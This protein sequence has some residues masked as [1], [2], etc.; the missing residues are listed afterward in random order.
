MLITF[1]NSI[2]TLLLNFRLGVILRVIP[3]LAVVIVTISVL[4]FDLSSTS[5]AYR[6]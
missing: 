5:Q 1:I 4:P 3:R 2:N 6:R